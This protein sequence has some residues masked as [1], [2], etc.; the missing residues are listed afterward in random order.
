MGGSLGEAEAIADKIK[1]KISSLQE[2]S[3]HNGLGFLYCTA[4]LQGGMTKQP[5]S[6]CKEGDK[7]GFR[8]Q[9]RFVIV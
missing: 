6:A 7:R 1:L 4:S 2:I 3:S 8:P 5:R 9:C